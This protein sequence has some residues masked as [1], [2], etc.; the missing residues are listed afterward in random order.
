[1]YNPLNICGNFI[2]TYNYSVSTCVKKKS[3]G[4]GSGP[5]VLIPRRI[6]STGLKARTGGLF[7]EFYPLRYPGKRQAPSTIVFKKPME[8][9]IGCNILSDM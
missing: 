9:E 4:L 8:S 5:W 7:P 1:M 3:S 6:G 2:I